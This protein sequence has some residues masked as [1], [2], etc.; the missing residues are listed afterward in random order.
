MLNKWNVFP[1]PGALTQPA[2]MSVIP[3]GPVSLVELQTFFL[4]CRWMV[5]NRGFPAS[6]IVE[7]PLNFF[8][9]AVTIVV[10]AVPEGLPLAVT[11]SLAYSLKKMM[12]DNNFVRVLAACETMGGATA[13]CSDKVP[14]SSASLHVHTIVTLYCCMLHGVSGHCYISCCQSHRA[15]CYRENEEVLQCHSAQ[16][17]KRL[18]SA[19]PGN[20][21]CSARILSTQNALRQDLRRDRSSFCP[22]FKCT[23]P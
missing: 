7:G 17:V 11:I 10:V 21:Y 1:D 9:F 14:F 12:K 23:K 13:I 6:K 16:S 18:P 19:L 4:A 2:V 20:A 3:L 8:I 5:E 15:T 22:C